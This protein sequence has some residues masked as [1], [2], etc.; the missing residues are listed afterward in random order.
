MVFN[1]IGSEMELVWDLVAMV[2]SI[3]AVMMVV[4]INGIIQKKGIL[5]SDVTRKIVHIFAGPVFIVTWILYSGG[6]FSRFFAMLV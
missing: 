3:I 6:V 2:I 4:Q 1:P 5:S